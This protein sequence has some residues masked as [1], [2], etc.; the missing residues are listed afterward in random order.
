MCSDALTHANTRVP[1]SMTQDWDSRNGYRARGI[2]LKLTSAIAQQK[3]LS[4][5]DM[6]EVQ[7]DTTSQLAIDLKSVLTLLPI[8]SLTNSAQDWQKRLLSWNDD[9]EVGSREG[10]MFAAWTVE[11]SKLV[12]TETGRAYWSDWAFLRSAYT[13][14]DPS[15]GGEGDIQA[16]GAQAAA[17]LNA[18]AKR[19]GAGS[20]DWGD[21]VHLAHFAHPTLGKGPLSCLC[22]RKLKH[23]GDE[24]S[25][26]VGGF[27]PASRCTYI[28]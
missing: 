8:G 24:S 22:N 13:S 26:N 12:A 5:E 15:C 18:A 6:K 7:L 17:A 2:T 27:D 4:V 28:K 19:L 9:M 25:A 11:L 14:G 21:S 16:C 10:S 23:G 1:I 3:L 20:V